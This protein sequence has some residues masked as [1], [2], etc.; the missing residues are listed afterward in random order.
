MFAYRLK[1]LIPIHE[2]TLYNEQDLYQAAYDFPWDKYFTQNESI[3]I[4]AVVFGE[5]LPIRC[6]FL[7]R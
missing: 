2:C 4:D 7:K 6:T 5:Y 1:I 3:A